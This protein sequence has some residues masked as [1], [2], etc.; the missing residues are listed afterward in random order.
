MEAQERTLLEDLLRGAGR[1]LLAQRRVLGWRQPPALTEM[2]EQ[3]VGPWAIEEGPLRPWAESM[4]RAYWACGGRTNTPMEVDELEMAVA[5]FA[6]CMGALE[7][8]DDL[9]DGDEPDGGRQA[10][11]LALAFIGESTLLLSRL[12]PAC[13]A[14]LLAFWGAMWTRCAAAQ[15]Q[16]VAFSTD[17]HVTVAQALAVAEGCGPFTRW[18]VEAGALLAGAP[19]ELRAPL[20]DFGQY[21]GTAEKLLH[22]VHDLWPDGHPSRDLHR[23]SCNLA[24]VV[25]RNEG[26]LPWERDVGADDDALRRRI[27][28]SGALHYAWAYADQYRLQAA[29]A[30]ERF[31]A[32][33]GDAA[34]L[35][36]VL[37]L[38]P[39]TRAADGWRRPDCLQWP[40]TLDVLNR[41]I[42]CDCVKFRRQVWPGRSSGQGLPPIC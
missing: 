2:L 32:A 33:G 36:P 40:C 8:F 24:L 14:P 34:P 39:E 27:H 6:A 26:V 19:A 22:D 9:I 30:L 18:A 29:G 1:R 13:A 28:D 11:N 17:P 38:P 12:S 20:S 4:I 23:P 15:A 42:S 31:A 41:D 35:V 16:D 3:G 21:L 25:A 7:I 10:P 37:A 5:A